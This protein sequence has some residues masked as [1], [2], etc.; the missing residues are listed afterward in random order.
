LDTKRPVV[1]VTGVS[2]DAGQGI[3]AGLRQAPSNPV[4]I[5]LD[6]TADNVGFVLCDQGIQV[7]AITSQEYLPLLLSIAQRL[8]ASMLFPGI[9]GEQ[10]LI[11]QS[12]D[13]FAAVGCVVVASDPLLVQIAGDKLSTSRWLLSHG[14]D[15]PQTWRADADRAE[16]EPRLPLIVKPRAGHG[17]QGVHLVTSPD[18]LAA[19]LAEQPDACVQEYIDGPEY[20]CSLLFDDASRLCDWLVTRRELRGGRTIRT[21]VVTEPCI[22]AYIQ[23]FAQ[24]ADG[25]RGSV[26]LQLRTRDARA[27]VFEINPRHSGSTSMR[28]AVGYNEPA[29]LLEHHLHGAPMTRADVVRGSVYRLWSQLVVPEVTP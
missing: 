24:A 29:R 13:A 26:N 20:T 19:R 28:V 9:D 11:A 22:E 27:W 12:R 10:L 4:I 6:Y 3:I 5:G 21:D 1:L 8:G 2:G 25:A 16:L 18:A 7:P 17:S 14:L 23:A 15:A